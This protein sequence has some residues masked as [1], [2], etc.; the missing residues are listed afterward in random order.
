MIP[1]RR[2]SSAL[3]V[4]I[5]VRIMNGVLAWTGQV[6]PPSVAHKLFPVSA[7]QE[8]YTAWLLEV[9]PLQQ[10]CLVDFIND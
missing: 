9:P 2:L 3:Q 8:E 5:N 4:I 10:K 1:R 6:Y 7:W